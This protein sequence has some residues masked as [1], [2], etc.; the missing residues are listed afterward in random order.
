MRER[1]K[2]DYVDADQTQPIRPPVE[3]G[4]T[5]NQDRK[6]GCGDDDQHARLFAATALPPPNDTGGR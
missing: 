2:D 6:Q 3:Q 4:R 5:V 1:K